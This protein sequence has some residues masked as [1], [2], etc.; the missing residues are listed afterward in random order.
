MNKTRIEWVKNPDGTRGYSSNPIKG[1]CPMACSYCY[2]RALYNRFRWD[3]TIRFDVGELLSIERHNK[4]AGI[5][6]G[7]TFELFWDELERFWQDSIF[8]TIKDCP[9]HHFYLLTKQPQNLIKFSPF[10]PNCWVGA[11]ATNLEQ[12]RAALVGL[13]TIEAKVKYISFEPLLEYIPTNPP[14]DLK[15]ID[16]VIIGAQTNPGK[17]PDPGWVDTILNACDIA[18]VPIFMKNNLAW[19]FHRQEMPDTDIER[20]TLRKYPHLVS[21]DYDEEVI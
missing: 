10:P 11:T 19:Q 17:Q 20:E 21:K 1:Y 9:Q 3:K 13:A 15:G 2:A 6:L 12:Y 5:F 14:Y 4:P 7:S 8:K 16:W 18:K